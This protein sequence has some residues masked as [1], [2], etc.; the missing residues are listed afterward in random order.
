[1]NCIWIRL[2]LRGQLA[3]QWRVLNTRIRDYNVDRGFQIIQFMLMCVYVMRTLKCDRNR[4]IKTE[5]IFFRHAVAKVT[6]VS[7]Y[8]YTRS[9]TKN[10]NR[11]VNAKRCVIVHNI[12]VLTASFA[13]IVT[14]FT[15]TYRNTRGGRSSGGGVGA[16]DHWYRGL[17]LVK[18]RTDFFSTSAPSVCPELSRRQFNVRRVVIT[19]SPVPNFCYMYMNKY[20]HI[21]MYIRS[22]NYLYSVFYS[23]V[24]QY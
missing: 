2:L 17:G 1:M 5:F 8:T 21:Y 4:L 10:T 11:H 7:V 16:A 14:E 18:R 3:V 20:I 19:V 24:V 6:W 13:T 22:S 15:V 12:A 9:C 23:F